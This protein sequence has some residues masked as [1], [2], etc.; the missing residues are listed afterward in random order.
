M[1]R[2]LRPLVAGVLASLLAV[3][4]MAAV[5]YTWRNATTAGVQ[6]DVLLSLIQAEHARV[7]PNT[8]SPEPRI[9]WLARYRSQDMVLNGYFSHVDPATGKRFWNYMQTAGIGY[10]AAAEI[11]AWNAY[12]DDLTAATAYR[13][14]MG[15]STHRAAIQSCTYTRIGV[16]TYKAGNK[17]M[18]TA[19]LVKP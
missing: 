19:I 16:G 13:Q 9:T 14:F 1:R 4:A 7:C 17:R 11:L 8:L 2:I 5:D 3:G 10:S 12:P 18:Y 6:Q 15:S